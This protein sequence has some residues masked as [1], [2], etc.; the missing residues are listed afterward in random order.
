MRS[1]AEYAMRG[2]RQAILAALLSGFFPLLNLISIAIVGLVNLRRDSKDAVLVAMWA[3]VPA[4]LQLVQR[5]DPSAVLMLPMIVI[6]ARVLRQTGRWQLV[7]VL[8]TVSGIGAQ[9]LLPLFSHYL[10]GLEELSSSLVASLNSQGDASPLTA[11]ELMEALRSYFGASVS[12]STLL[13]LM[14]ARWWQADEVNPGGFRQEFHNLKLEPATAAVYFA[15]L[16]VG[17]MGLAPFEGM[18]NIML[19]TPTLCGLGAAHGLLG[20]RGLP[21]HWL[22][23]VYVVLLLFVPV[24]AA[25]GLTDSVADFRQRLRQSLAQSDERNNQP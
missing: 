6:L 22:I 10:A 12:V 16:L 24:L 1:L 19:V 21:G 7:L 14:L 11:S 8:A 2:R 4:I 9:L 18:V 17:M 15:A 13:C 25:F 23:G 5:G 3:A 20:L